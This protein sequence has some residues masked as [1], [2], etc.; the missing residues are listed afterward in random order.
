MTMWL[1]ILVYKQTSHIRSS[2]MGL[3]GVVLKLLKFIEN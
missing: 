2:I 3:V 1:Y